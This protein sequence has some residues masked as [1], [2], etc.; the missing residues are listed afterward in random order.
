MQKVKALLDIKLVELLEGFAEHT[1]SVRLRTY[2]IVNYRDWDKIFVNNGYTN[3]DFDFEL[4]KLLH[5]IELRQISD[6][7]NKIKIYFKN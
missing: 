7:N 2:L 3:T 1:R 5:N 4:N 6:N